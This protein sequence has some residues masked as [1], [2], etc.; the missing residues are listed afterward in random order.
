MQKRCSLL[1]AAI[2]AG[3]MTACSANIEDK[4]ESLFTPYQG[5]GTPGAAV[6]VIKDGK[7]I[8]TRSFGLADIDRQIAVTAA[9]NF[10]LAS[11]T[12][13]FTAMSIMMLVEEGK[14]SL[15]TTLP[16]VI[17]GFPDYANDITIRHVLQHRSGLLDYESIMSDDATEQVH[18]SDVLRMM[19]EADHA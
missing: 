15:D 6:R 9:T 2:L 11:V 13:Q 3:A 10:R 18:D 19:I 5:D 14:L 17:E 12:K 1:V 4:V 16:P 7:P 8:L